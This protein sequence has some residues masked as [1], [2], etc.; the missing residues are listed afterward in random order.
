TPRRCVARAPPPPRQLASWA[1]RR[2]QGAPEP[3]VDLDEQWAVADAFLAA[4]RDGDFEALLAVLDPDVVSRSH[5][6]PERP[7]LVSSARGAQ[8]VAQQAMSFRRFAES[9]SRVLVNGTP[10]GVAWLPD[11]RPFAG[12]AVTIRG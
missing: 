7:Q 6:G 2:V 11:G 1:R 3:D 12:G 4:A 9:A 5:A 10:G 8:A